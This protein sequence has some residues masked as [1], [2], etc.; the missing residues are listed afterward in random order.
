M[1]SFK[2][3]V[4]NSL[5]GKSSAGFIIY[6]SFFTLPIAKNPA[7]IV[8]PG[9]VCPLHLRVGAAKSLASGTTSA[10]IVCPPKHHEQ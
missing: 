1:Q 3:S 9:M 4:K 7:S 5:Q 8:I 6:F 2:K 10:T